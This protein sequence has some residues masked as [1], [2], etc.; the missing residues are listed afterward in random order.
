MCLTS[1]KEK[2][3]EKKA[4]SQEIDRM[5]RQDQKRN[6]TRIKLLLLGAGESGKS[7][8]LKQ[9]K[10]IN[11]DGFS[12]SERKDFWRPVIFTNL[13]S[14]FKV[15]L[16][17]MDEYGLKLE[18]EESIRCAGMI[19]ADPEVHAE[20][21]YPREY[22]D[23]CLTLWD[24]PNF[25]SGIQKGH[26]YALHDNINYFFSNIQR[27]FAD[28]YLPNDQDILRSRLRTTGI[29]ETTFDLGSVTYHMYDVGGQRSERKKWIHC[30]EGVNCLLFLAAVSG[31]DQCLIEDRRSN[32]M[33]EALML[34]DSIVNS[35]WF[36]Q[37]A[38]ILFLNKVDLFKAKLATSSI[39]RYF[40]DFQADDEDYEAAKKFF[41]NKFIHLNRSPTREIYVHFTNATDTNL[42]KITMTSVQDMILQRNISN[43]LL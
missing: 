10:L 25:K 37:S 7:T 28:D 20:Q 33:Y 14:A 21:K 38:M 39:R 18:N 6:Q 12:K 30:F 17:N 22:L 3:D 27:L 34:F 41:A 26:E 19:L 24:D 40:P 43:L 31:Y 4:R 29:T 35:P 8:V 1:R 15:V 23:V 13:V 32:Q 16:E 9:M 11:A 5:I 42:L 2:M 36:K